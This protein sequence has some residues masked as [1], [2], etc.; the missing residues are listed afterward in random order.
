VNRE[1]EKAHYIAFGAH[2]KCRKDDGCVFL[3][4]PLIV[5][6]IFMA[7][8]LARANWGGSEGATKSL[9]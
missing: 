5:S 8:L 2:T 4:I 1:P 7:I 6:H 3:V 9:S